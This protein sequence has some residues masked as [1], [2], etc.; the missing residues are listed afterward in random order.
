ML[1]H[2]LL[3]SRFIDEGVVLLTVALGFSAPVFL[4][5]IPVVFAV[6]PWG[7]NGARSRPGGALASDPAISSTFLKYAPSRLT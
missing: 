3:D 7:R 4:V 6:M 5:V 1:G 2:R